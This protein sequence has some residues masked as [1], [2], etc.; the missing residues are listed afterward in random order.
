MANI[1]L[2]FVGNQ[3]DEDDSSIEVYA[4]VNNEVFISIIN[5]DPE[6]PPM[7][8]RLDLSTAIRFD[9]ELRKAI[10]EIKKDS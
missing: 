9:K 7:F 5:N 6:E 1:R 2:Q 8:I 10:S 3:L 4:N